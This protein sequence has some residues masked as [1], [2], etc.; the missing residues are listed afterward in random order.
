[1]DRFHKAYALRE[2]KATDSGNGGFEGYASVFGVRDDGGDVIVKG[3]FAADLPA[4][5]ERGFIGYGHDWSGLPIGYVKDAKEDDYGLRITTEYHGTQ[6]AQEARTVAQERMG[7]GK[8][9]Y[10]SIGYGINPGGAEYTEDGSTRVLKSLYLYETSQ[11]NV[12]MNAY[13]EMTDAKGLKLVQQAESTLAVA[14]A[15][16][17]RCKSLAEL[18][19]KEGRVLSDKNRETLSS[20]AGQMKDAAEAITKLLADTA[21]KARNAEA[22]RLL[23]EWQQ[24]QDRLTRIA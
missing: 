9:V 17:E 4:F 15:F 21:P 8:G 2:F 12:P 16:I 6:A 23:A 10:L 7:A 19:L 1:M 11:V 14:N 22:L 18:R 13:A 20:I 3:A 24:T 5:I